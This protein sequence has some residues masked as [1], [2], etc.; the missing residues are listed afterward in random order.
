MLYAKAEK[1]HLFVKVKCESQ[2]TTNPLRGGIFP[3]YS[4]VPVSYSSLANQLPSV[5]SIHF[6]AANANLPDYVV[7][8]IFIY[9]PTFFYVFTCTKQFVRKGWRAYESAKQT[10]Y[11]YTKFQYD[12]VTE[13]SW[14]SYQLKRLEESV[15][16]IE[17]SLCEYIE[18]E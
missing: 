2:E 18:E 13:S 7:P 15:N 1:E 14:E 16:F 12:E 6:K 8:F 10:K 5:F 11:V 4:K 3:S 17:E 9:S